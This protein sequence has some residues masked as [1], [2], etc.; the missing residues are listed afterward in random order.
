MQVED[1]GLHGDVERR[2]R[3]V[4]DECDRVA[5]DRHRDHRALQLTAGEFVRVAT[6]RRGAGS[7]IPTEASSSPTRSPEFAR[8]PASPCAAEG[9]R[10]LVGR[11]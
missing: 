2:G 7:A 10:D 5:R 9:L 6:G 8:P 4:G 3:L 1:A 11:S